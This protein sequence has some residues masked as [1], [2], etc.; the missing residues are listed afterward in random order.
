MHQ[1]VQIEGFRRLAEKARDIPEPALI[2][3]IVSLQGSYL[4]HARA[5]IYASKR[6]TI[7]G[8]EV[9]HGRSRACSTSS[10]YP[11]KQGGLS[12]RSSETELP[13]CSTTIAAVT[14]DGEG[15][16]GASSIAGQGL[17]IAF[18]FVSD[19]LK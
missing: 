13:G 4:E 5:M 7:A 3:Q 16:D 18:N 6:G 15:Q 14:H 8:L 2:F 17:N 1:M 11:L 12:V 10:G 9:E 19:L